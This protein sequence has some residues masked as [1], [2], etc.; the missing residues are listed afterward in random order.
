MK[1]LTKFAFLFASLALPAVCVAN[2]G[3]PGAYSSGFIGVSAPA[4]IDTPSTNFDSNASFSDRVKLDPGINIGGTGGYDFGLLRLEGELSYKY[5]T[6]KSITDQTTNTPFK[7][8]KGNLGVLAFMFNGFVDLHNES[9]ITPYVGGGVGFATLNLSDTYGS[10]STGSTAKRV[11]LYG[12]GNDTVFAYQAGAGLDIA[13]NRRL[14]L[15][16]GYRYFNCSSADFTADQVIY[17]SMKFVSHT[18]AIG[19]RIK[20]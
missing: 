7:N 2:P 17:T 1:K 10:E 5:S 4:S 11:R 6:I 3:V 9:R 19:L 8:P 16:I 12:A 18:T 20:Y 15:D 13:L 14:S